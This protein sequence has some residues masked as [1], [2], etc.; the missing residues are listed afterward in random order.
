MSRTLIRKNQ[1]HPDIADLV[2]GY[3]DSFF[4]TPSEVNQLIG[5]EIEKT[6]RI[7]G[8][9]AVDGVKN[10]TSRPTVNGT[11]VLLIG[12]AAAGGGVAVS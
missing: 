8:N 10:F 12:E 3:G 4:T 6:V 11:G 1:L 2:S 7:T 9:Q 5:L